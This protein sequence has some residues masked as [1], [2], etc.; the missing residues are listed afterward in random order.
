MAARSDD[1]VGRRE[2]GVALYVQSTLQSS[3]WTYLADNPLYELLWIHVGNDV[4]VAALYHPPK[5][6][7]KPA[8]ILELIKACLKELGGFFPAAHI[9]LAGDINQLSNED[10]EK[11]TGLRREHSRPS[12][13]VEPSAVQHYPCCD[14]SCS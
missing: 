10:I 6:I 13:C 2:R 8:E 9:I 11:K 4:F 5:P 12:L 7:Y 14:V 3:V 1:R